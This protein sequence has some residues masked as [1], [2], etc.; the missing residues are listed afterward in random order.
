MRRALTSHVLF[1][2]H[3]TPGATE[4]ESG[5]DPPLMT[6]LRVLPPRKPGIR[7]GACAF[8][9]S[10]KIYL[11]KRYTKTPVNEKGKRDKKQGEPSDHRA[12]WAPLKGG[13]Q[14]RR[15]RKKISAWVLGSPG[16]KVAW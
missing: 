8:G 10:E 4:Q 11:C 7:D 5:T 15:F 14:G 13:S 3:V 6:P 12:V 9:S 2:V 16:A 1:K